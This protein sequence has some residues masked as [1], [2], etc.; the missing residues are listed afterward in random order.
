MGW[1]DALLSRHGPGGFAGVTLGH[2][3][4]VLR[5]IGF[6]V[7]RR[8]WGRAAAITW[9]S[10]PNTILGG[11][12][13]V[14][15]GRRVR[16]ARVG[17]PVF[18]LGVWRSGTTHLHNLLARDE[19]FAFPNTFQ[20]YNPA[21][22]LLTERVGRRLADF[23]MPPT[24][25]QDN[26]AIRAGLP[27]EDEFAVC[28]L[29]GLSPMMG[30]VAPRRAA[31]YD[32]YLTF[33]NATPGERARWKAALFGFV[34]KLSFRYGGRPLVL[35]SPAHTGRVRLLL[36]LFPDARFVHIHRNPYEV[37]QSTVHLLRTAGPWWALQ[38]DGFEDSADRAIRQYRE[39]Y[40]AFFEDR[41]LI[42]AG[43]YCEVGF[44][45]VEADPVGQLRGVYEALGLPDFGAV[46]PAL[47]RY[48]AGLTGYKKNTHP[49]IAP[50]HRDRIAREWRRCFEEWGYAT[51]SVG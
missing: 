34:Q 44:E 7:D 11:A 36:E 21:T 32:R 5:G 43:R 42:P 18:V 50:D 4:G 35:K 10:V 2:W 28:G 27:Q 46:E 20:V 48:V 3:L 49:E 12:E 16:R 13:R 45:A 37:F 9:G 30:W 8:Y 33:R 17:P 1:R 41:G 38:R 15:Y 47:E 39:L 26:M 24:R 6:A 14:V 31:G 29:T 19:R 22:F 25:P 23:V 40:D 51:G